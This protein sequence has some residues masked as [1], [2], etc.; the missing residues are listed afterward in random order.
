MLQV[1][2]E[3]EYAAQEVTLPVQVSALSVAAPEKL[4]V[5]RVIQGDGEPGLHFARLGIGEDQQE[6]GAVAQQG[7]GAPWSCEGGQVRVEIVDSLAL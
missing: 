2:L 3:R 5:Q 4:I 1:L 7:E 6:R